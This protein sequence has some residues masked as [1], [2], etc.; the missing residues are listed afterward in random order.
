MSGAY[1]CLANDGMYNK[2]M[3]LFRIEDKNGK[4][5]YKESPESHPAIKS[6]SNYVM[7][8]LLKNVVQGAPGV[9]ELKSEVGGKTGTT[10]DFV[11]G[12]FMGITPGL[13][14]GT[15]VGGD[16]RWVRFLDIADGQGARMAR[17]FF[18]KFIKKLEA[19]PKSGYDST[20]K[21]KV[22]PGDLDIT[23][24]CGAYNKASAEDSDEFSENNFEN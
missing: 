9:S 16:D 24:D 15:W 22:P 4:L 11:D 10:N 5:L 13:T 12:W 17:P 3:Y 18:A 21:F 14:V 8:Q 19:D 6:E 7:V 23:L 1:A 20:K 2:P